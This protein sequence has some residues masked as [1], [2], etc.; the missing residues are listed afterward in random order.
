MP[1]F[2]H[3]LVMSPTICEASIVCASAFDKTASCWMMNLGQ[4]DR[5]LPPKHMLYI[6]RDQDP[7]EKSSASR[8][9]A[10]LGLSE[11]P[12]FHA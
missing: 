11:H 9:E 4:E 8:W 3:D 12:V 2:R 7:C 5:S 6:T 1:D 10:C